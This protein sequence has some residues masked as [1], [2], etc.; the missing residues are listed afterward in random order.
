MIYIWF[1]SILSF[2]VCGVSCWSSFIFLH[3]SVQ[4]SQH[5]LL[6]RLFYS[7]LC[8]LSLCQILIYHG[9][10]DLFLGSLFCSIGLCVCFYAG[11]RW[12]DYSGLVIQFDIR[13]CDPSRFVLLSQNCCSYSGS[14]M[15]PYEFLKCLFYMCEIC[16][17]YFNR[18]CIESINHFG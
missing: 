12:F 18:N 10:M 6:K 17:G 5:H 2:L 4:I 15:V 11:T 14:F 9:D 1:I 13:H 16:L 3:V 7:N 8:F